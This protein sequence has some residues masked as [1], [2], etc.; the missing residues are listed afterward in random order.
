MMPINQVILGGD[1]LLS[2]SIVGNNLEEQI[3]LLE[4][5]KQNL[6]LAKQTKQQLQIYPTQQKLIWD[7]IDSEI[8]PMSEEQRMMLFQDEDYTD[9][10]NRLQILVQQ[11]LLNLVK[12][13]IES[14]PEGKEL[15]VQQLKSVKKLKTRIINDT[16]KEMEMFRKFKE[17]SKNNPE[18]TY[19]EFIKASM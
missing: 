9:L 6:E 8:Q 16:N 18:V 3:Q 17:Y 4:K 5:Y 13:R 10:Y 19:D 15:L 1:P 14:I 2:N 7:E 11:E 12:S